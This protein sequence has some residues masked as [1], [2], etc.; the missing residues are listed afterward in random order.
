MTVLQAL[1][2]YYDRMAARNEAE[3]PGYS[4]E[5]IS[6]AIVL[7][8]DGDPIQKLDL[9]EAVGRRMVPRL[10][11]VPAAVKRTAGILP[12]LLWDKTSYVLGRTAGERRRTAEEHTAFKAANLAMLDGASDEGLIALCRF[13]EAW[14]PARFDATPFTPEML[15]A[16]IVFRLDGELG[17]VHQRDAARR[18]IERRVGGDGPMGLCL[19]SGVEAPLRRLHP[20]I[21]G[22]EGAQSSGASLVS[23]N[24]DAFTSY[25]KEQGANAPVSEAAAFRYGAALNRMLDRGSSNRIAHPIGDASV[26]FWADTSAVVAE[27]AAAEAA[28]KAAESAF[29]A[30]FDQIAASDQEADDASEAAKLRDALDMLAK[31]RPVED[32]SLG[33]IPGTRF[34]VLGLAPNAAR[35]SVRYWLDDSFD[36]FA[37]RLADHYRDLAIEPAPWGARPPSVQRLLVKTTALQEKFDNIPPLLAGE[38]MRA[39]LSGTRYPRILLTAAIIRL[40]A[41]DDPWTGWHAAAI[42]ACINRSEEENVPMA[43]EPDNPSA[44]YQLGRLFAVL[45]S[46]QYA[47]LGRVNAPI[48]TRYYGS[49]SATPARVF[50]PL[51]RGLRHHVADALKQGRG[52]WIDGKVGEI[53]AKLPPNLPP[54]LRL[55]DQGRFAVGYYHERAFRR[56]SAD[57]IDPGE[58]EASQ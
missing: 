49:A 46:A 16:N 24:L 2:R 53:I 31:G 45:E 35:L 4:R 5:K 6:F 39:V 11:E 19:V 29:A 10:I 48:S 21:K 44:A 37:R 23:F 43:L 34:H 36:A 1:D 58:E 30:W 25:G 40:R 50:G 3:A 8:A 7:S 9:R 47:A 57:E 33:L 26:V 56:P 13:L 15:D 20:S 52:G 18:M 17:Y 42:K 12:N 51:L 14:S 32:L 22:V 28:A 54:T 27:A 55:E 38:V 41:G